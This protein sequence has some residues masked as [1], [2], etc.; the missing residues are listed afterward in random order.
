MGCQ[1]NLNQLNNKSTRVHVIMSCNKYF[2]TIYNYH[3]SVHGCVSNTDR[4]P[5]DKD[6]P[7]TDLPD[8]ATVLRDHHLVALKELKKVRSQLSRVNRCLSY[9][10]TPTLGTSSKP[11]HIDST[12]I[13]T[14]LK[15]RAY[16]CK[17]LMIKSSLIKESGG[18]GGRSNQSS[19]QDFGLHVTISV[20]HGIQTFQYLKFD[21]WF[22]G[23]C[24]LVLLNIA[25]FFGLDNTFFFISCLPDHSKLI[26]H[27]RSPF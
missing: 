5:N 16:F 23:A 20:W 11:F 2:F 26:K 13:Q 7:I 15:Y 14:D 25:F 17:F 27:L 3:T 19:I 6:W 18:E 1:W 8:L 22:C 10:I 24:R 9:L 21:R 12:N 4:S